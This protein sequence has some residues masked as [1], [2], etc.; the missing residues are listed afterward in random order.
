MSSLTHYDLLKKIKIVIMGLNRNSL[1]Y[2][3][4]G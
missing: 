3:I 4:K 2:L 1:D